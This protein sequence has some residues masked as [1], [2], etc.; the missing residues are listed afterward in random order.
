MGSVVFIHGLANKPRPEIVLEQWTTALAGARKDGLDLAKLGVTY[1][2]VY[3]ADVL[4]KAPE[5]DTSEGEDVQAAGED[6]RDLGESPEWEADLTDDERKFVEG[7]RGKL[8]LSVEEVHLR[9]IGEE[10]ATG[11]RAFLLPKPLERKLM[12]RLL[13][14]AYLYLYGKTYEP[15][16]GER[17]DVKAEIRKR[18]VTAVDAAAKDGGPVVVVSH[19][20]GTMIAYDCLR[21]VPEAANVAGLIT[22]GSPLGLSEVQDGWGKSWEKRIAFPKDKVPERAWHNFYD[23][24]DIV[25]ALDPKLANDYKREG[26]SVIGDARVRNVGSWR[27]YIREYLSRDAVRAALTKLLA[28]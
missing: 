25:C 5:P 11:E 8:Q 20:M 18:F 16:P 6:E 24:L 13:K 15:R 2:M 7:L 21:H 28:L 3:W 27:H 17:F 26:E 4:Y 9:A 22:L 19:S 10:A 23:R 1:R 12:A 14:D